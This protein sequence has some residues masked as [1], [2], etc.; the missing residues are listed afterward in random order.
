MGTYSSL[1]C[2]ACKTT[3]WCCVLSGHEVILCDSR[4]VFQNFQRAIS[5]VAA[6]LPSILP[7]AGASSAAATAAGGAAATA[8]A[9]G[10][11]S[12]RNLQLNSTSVRVLYLFTRSAQRLRVLVWRIVVVAAGAEIVPCLRCPASFRARVST[13]CPHGWCTLARTTGSTD[14]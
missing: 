14:W 3:T 7:G 10:E 12:G 1:P 5:Q 8:A 9:S 13:C 2:N 6:H 11:D 4:S